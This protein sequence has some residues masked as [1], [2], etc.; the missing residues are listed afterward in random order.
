MTFVSHRF[1]A[2]NLDAIKALFEVIHTQLTQFQHTESKVTAHSIEQLT[3]KLK[4]L[5]LTVCAL[6]DSVHSIDSLYYIGMQ[7]LFG[8]FDTC[9]N[10]HS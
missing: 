7:L 10:C 4:E 2:Q 3:R 9:T 6:S 8:S 1:E 5:A